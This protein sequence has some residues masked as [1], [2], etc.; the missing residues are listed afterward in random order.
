[1]HTYRNEGGSR[2]EDAIADRVIPK[3]AKQKHLSPGAYVFM[4]VYMCVCVCVFIRVWIICMHTAC[5]AH[6]DVHVELYLTMQNRSICHQVR[7]YV[8]MYVCMYVCL[9]IWG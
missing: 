2:W 9:Y 3:D 4:Y 8:C 6:M 1:M 7:L 5:M